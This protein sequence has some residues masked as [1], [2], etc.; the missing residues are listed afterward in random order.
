[1]YARGQH[2]QRLHVQGGV[3]PEPLR[4]PPHEAG[5]EDVE[6]LKMLA[7]GVYVLV[8]V[9]VCICIYVYIYIYI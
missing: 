6:T 3:P 7:S 5:L 1:M 2:L 9:Y 4:G 8:Y